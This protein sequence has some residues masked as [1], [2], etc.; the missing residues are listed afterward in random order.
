[1]TS[2]NFF[3]LFLFV[4]ALTFSS[5]DVGLAARN[6]LFSTPLPKFNFPPLSSN[7]WPPLFSFPSPPPPPKTIIPTIPFPFL[8]PPP[9]TTNP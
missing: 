6:L 1:M 7:N 9:S 5:M 4:A 2:S 8:F 3:V